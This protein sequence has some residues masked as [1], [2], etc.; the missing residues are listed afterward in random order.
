M[1][2]FIRV[3]S[4]FLLLFALVTAAACNARPTPDQPAATGTPT[5]GG[6]TST[7]APTSVF[8]VATA[9]GTTTGTEPTPGSATQVRSFVLQL[10]IDPPGSGF[11]AAIPPFGPY[12]AGTT[13]TLSVIPPRVPPYF[14]STWG[15]DATGARA[16]TR[17]VMDSDKRVVAHFINPAFTP[18]PASEE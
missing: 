12:A 16:S 2:L 3:S 11:I 14:F 6:G 4:V 5:P 7:L 18:T 1:G 9:S 17:V 10:I 13:V 8:P 15:G